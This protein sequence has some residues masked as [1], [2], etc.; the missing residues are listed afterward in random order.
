MKITVINSRCCQFWPKTPKSQQDPT[1]GFGGIGVTSD[2]RD[3]TR[4]MFQAALFEFANLGI[5]EPTQIQRIP[6]QRMNQ[7]RLLRPS[8]LRP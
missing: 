8:N 3:Q 7:Y 6:S 5:T 2:T 1:Q 4:E